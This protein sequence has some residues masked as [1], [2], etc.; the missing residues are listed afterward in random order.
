[1]SED[2]T[3]TTVD[4]AAAPAATDPTKRSPYDGVVTSPS[5][6]LAA[7]RSG[8][9]NFIGIRFPDF[10]YLSGADLSGAYLSGADLSG[11]YLRGAD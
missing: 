6:F 2:T 5:D 4:A 3:T 9:R 1:M 8:E 7:Y 10:S 11:A